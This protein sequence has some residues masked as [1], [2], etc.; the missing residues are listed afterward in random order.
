[1]IAK[2]TDK[3]TTIRFPP[4]VL[5]RLE[6]EASHNGRSRNSEIVV[7]LMDS[8]NAMGDRGPKNRRKKITIGANRES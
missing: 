8:L 1:M 2:R 7:R 5:E 4:G 3:A 6:A